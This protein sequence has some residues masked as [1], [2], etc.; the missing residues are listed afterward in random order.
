MRAKYVL[1]DLFLYKIGNETNIYV[2]LM[3]FVSGWL[4]TMHIY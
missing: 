3:L 4:L 1:H 2:P